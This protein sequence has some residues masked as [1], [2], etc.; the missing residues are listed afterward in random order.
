LNLLRHLT[1]RTPSWGHANRA[2]RWTW[3]RNA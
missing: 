1:L 2:R 3:T